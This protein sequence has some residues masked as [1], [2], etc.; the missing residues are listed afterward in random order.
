MRRAT[1]RPHSPLSA[2][3]HIGAVRESLIARTSR[4]SVNEESGGASGQSVVVNGA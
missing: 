1:P 3:I 2:A 4:V